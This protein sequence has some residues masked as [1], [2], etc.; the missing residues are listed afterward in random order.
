MIIGTPQQLATVSITSFRVGKAVTTSVATGRKM[1]AHG[2]IHRLRWRLMF[3][4]HACNSAFTICTISDE[5]ENIS[6]KKEKEKT[7]VHAFIYS[8]VDHCNSLL[9]GLPGYQIKKLQQN[10]GGGTPLWNRRGCSS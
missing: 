10:P 8:R 3:R 9:Y 2:L 7:L 4:K 6:P 1:K 5:R